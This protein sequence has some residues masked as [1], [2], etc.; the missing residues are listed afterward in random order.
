VTY[1]TGFGLDDWIYCTLYVHTTRYYMQYSAVPILHTLSFT[2]AHAL[3]FSV[4]TSR[5]LATD[6]SLFQCNFNS[7]VT[8][9]LHH[10]IPFLFLFCNCQFRRLEP[11][12]FRLWFR[13][14]CHSASTDPVLLSTSHNHFA[15]TPRKTQSRVVKNACLL[16]H[17]LAMDVLLLSACVAR[18][19][20][21]ARC[22]A[23]GIQVAIY[24]NSGH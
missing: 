17:Y 18:M 21:P 11:I 23:M 24:L 4:F 12:L 3:G 2:A 8:F 19:R 20:L 22:L 14:P 16:L 7:K 15:R 13:A 10:L 5:I 6:L 9:S 1:K